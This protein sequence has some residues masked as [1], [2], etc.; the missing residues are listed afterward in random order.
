[1][2]GGGRV[3]PLVGSMVAISLLTSTETMAP[4]SFCPSSFLPKSAHDTSRS[5]LCTELTWS[6]VADDNVCD[7]LTVALRFGSTVVLYLYQ[8]LKFQNGSSSLTDAKI[9]ILLSKRHEKRKRRPRR[10]LHFAVTIPPCRTGDICK[11]SRWQS[12][13]YAVPSVG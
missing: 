5:S 3:I 7:L 11:A 2:G 13:P 9:H 1:M 12:T 10:N 8:L 4:F 6:R